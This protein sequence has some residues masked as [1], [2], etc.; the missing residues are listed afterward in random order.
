M[1]PLARQ[2]CSKNP[3]F[4]QA[5]YLDEGG[6]DSPLSLFCSEA[7]VEE[8]HYS[9]EKPRSPPP[10][11]VA[12]G[13]VGIF[14]SHVGRHD[15]TGNGASTKIKTSGEGIAR[16]FRS[17]PGM[18]TSLS[19]V[20]LSQFPD[21]LTA[22]LRHQAG[23]DADLAGSFLAEISKHPNLVLLAK[24]RLPETML[25]GLGAALRMWTWE[26]AG[27]QIHR[28]AG[29]PCAWAAVRDVFLSL[30]DSEAA[31]RTV[32]LPARVTAL[33]IDRF[34]WGAA[35]QLDATVLLGDVDNDGLIDAVAEFLW[36]HRHDE[37]TEPK[38]Q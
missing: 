30:V 21:E 19:P 23:S 29:L 27:I 11:I 12:R 38:H 2:Q 28:E 13:R 17:E 36:R 8:F 15:L 9:Q 16:G 24:L 35:A 25:L 26:D 37:L 3:F 1:Q 32:E 33:F 4:G 31:A 18:D 34:A 10:G 22:A 7:P 20:N 5:R 6:M 14:L